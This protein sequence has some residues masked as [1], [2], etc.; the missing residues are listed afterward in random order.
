ML[1]LLGTLRAKRSDDARR[2]ITNGSL[3]LN[4]NRSRKSGTMKIN[5]WLIMAGI[6]SAICFSPRQLLAQDE[7]AAPPRRGNFDPA[8]M[9]TRMLERLKEQME[10]TDDSE[11]KVIQPLVQNVMDARAAGMGGMG[12]MFG[13]GRRPGENADQGGTARRGPF[14]QAPS[15]EAE[16]LQKAID[17]KAS[18]AELKAAIAK[19]AE[20]KKAKQ[21]ELEKAQAELRKVLTVRQE[22]IAT[23]N[24]LL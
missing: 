11:W 5:R 3:S 6:V 19:Y 9:R 10:V 2:V 16:A 8:Q 4:K 21:A 18:N 1:F 13:P 15:A 24:G 22:A 20:Y 7:Q 17:A 12:R 14:G 23:V